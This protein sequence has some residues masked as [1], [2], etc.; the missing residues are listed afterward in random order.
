MASP[1]TQ[2]QPI[3]IMDENSPGIKL[4]M[5]KAAA[6]TIEKILDQNKEILGKAGE[7]CV[8][9]KVATLTSPSKM[10]INQVCPT[11]CAPVLNQ[12]VDTT[13]E[14]VGKKAVHHVV[15][16]CAPVAKKVADQAI[17]ISMN[18]ATACSATASTYLSGSY[19]YICDKFK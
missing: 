14:V 2:V 8:D 1:I 19:T 15:D 6:E 17:E 11:A 9:A 7:A 18:S 10:A 4:V 3:L 12:M 5:K 16:N 13:V